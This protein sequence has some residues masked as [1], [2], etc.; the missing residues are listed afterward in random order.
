[1]TKVRLNDAARSFLAVERPF[2]VG[3][4]WRRG[5]GAP[6]MSIV[7]PSSGDVIAHASQATERDVDDAVRAARAAFESR[8]W[9][10]M[11]PSER[12]RLLWKLSELVESNADELLH[13][14]VANQGLP[15]S[16][17]REFVIPGVIETFRYYAGW[18]TKL[19]GMTSHVS[20]P[21][22]R[23]AG[24]IGAAYH[25]YTSYE[26]IG[27]VGAIIPWN[28]PLI[29]AAAKLAPAL[30]AG[31]AVVLKP[32][33]ETPLSA[34]RLAELVLEA[35]FPVGVVNVIAGAGRI[36]GAALAAHPDVDKIAFTGSTE[37]GRSIART[38]AADMKKVGLE[39]GGKS[40][41]IVFADANIEAAIKG[42]G[43]AIFLN[44]GQVCFAGSRLLVERSCLDRVLDGV[45][46]IAKSMRLGS[47]DDDETEMG[48]LISAKQKARVLDFFEK[49]DPQISIIAGGRSAGDRGYFVE[50][51]VALATSAEARLMREEVF[52]PVLSV[53]GF[54]SV[55]EAAALANQTE[56]GLAAGVW[57]ND[58]RK[59]HNLADEIRAG[60]VW[61]N[62][63]NALDE[64]MTFGGYKQ[65][66]WGRE[67]SRAG[68][69][70]YMES[71][72]V[73]MAV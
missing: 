72:S 40:P 21:D 28:F 53:I 51:T 62:C 3:E 9:R 27:V 46:A 33:D 45:A 29:M 52:G 38:A 68:V 43:E 49:P 30:A 13:L 6:P 64:A 2:L 60:T 23:P 70:A 63:H 71:K 4:E 1:M 56:Y 14:E 59:A 61:V 69:E 42:A 20:L 41:V 35:G 8:A 31:C 73:V 57:T 54:D 12:T 25:A 58:L 37:V 19:T 18:C 39:L 34:L 10:R 36:V 26:P 17:A 5:A 50:P 24:A 16:V 22:Q 65:S 7:N 32:A 47:A 66:G 48:P 55:E 15:I 67:G 11:P 44:T